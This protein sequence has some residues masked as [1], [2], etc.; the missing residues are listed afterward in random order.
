[1]L[2]SWEYT[3]YIYIYELIRRFFFCVWNWGIPHMAISMGKIMINENRTGLVLDIAYAQP[4]G[5][6]MIPN[7]K[8]YWGWLKHQPE[9]LIVNGS[10]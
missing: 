5:G 8:F 2:I 7:S 10:D 9:K 1:M 3:L 4:Q 6:I